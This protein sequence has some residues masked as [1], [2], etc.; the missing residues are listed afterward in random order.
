MSITVLCIYVFLFAASLFAY[1]FYS[2]KK[3]NHAKPILTT[4]SDDAN[5]D[6]LW[7]AR[8]LRAPPERLFKW[9]RAMVYVQIFFC[10]NK[11]NYELARVQ[12]NFAWTS[13]RV[14]I[15]FHTHF[16]WRQRQR[17]RTLWTHKAHT[18]YMSRPID[19]YNHMLPVVEAFENLKKK[20]DPT[21]QWVE[22]VHGWIG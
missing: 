9:I 20:H 15:V 18:T 13:S 14:E 1:I 10:N 6:A 16:Q 3:K 12:L 8:A 19:V 4:H 7:L 21:E 2:L 5:S 11:Q 17:H 22:R